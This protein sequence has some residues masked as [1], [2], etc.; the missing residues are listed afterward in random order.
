MNDKGFLRLVFSD[1]TAQGR[2]HLILLKM[3]VLNL[4]GNES[5][6]GFDHEIHLG[7]ILGSPV[8]QFGS[9]ES[10]LFLFGKAA[11]PAL[12]GS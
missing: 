6:S 4:D 12:C 8:I 5:F 2:R 7:F 3:L 9:L 1:E 11:V 10:S